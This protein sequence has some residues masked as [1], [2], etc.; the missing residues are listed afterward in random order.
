MTEPRAMTPT[1]HWTL[2]AMGPG[3][4]MIF[5]DARDSRR[6]AVGARVDSRF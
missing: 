5:L 6:T 4:F 1:Q 2:L 3:L